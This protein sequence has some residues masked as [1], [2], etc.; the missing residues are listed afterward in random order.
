MTIVYGNQIE[1]GGMELDNSKCS[2]ECP[3]CKSQEAVSRHWEECEG[4]SINAYS[5]VSCPD[6]G[7][8]EG[9]DPND[10]HT[11]FDCD[12]A[13][14][15]EIMAD[16]DAEEKAINRLFPRAMRWVRNIGYGIRYGIKSRVQNAKTYVGQLVAS[17]K[18]RLPEI[19][20]NADKKKWELKLK[21]SLIIINAKC[22]AFI[23]LN[24]DCQLRWLWSLHSWRMGYLNAIYALKLLILSPILVPLWI[25]V[26][27]GRLTL[28]ESTRRNIMAWALKRPWIHQKLR[29]EGVKHR[30]VMRSLEEVRTSMAM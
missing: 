17:A 25:S 19:K 27:V 20:A 16:L 24:C 26:Q 4:G 29:D 10:D 18:A 12:N 28:Q 7:Y 13:W 23:Y 14:E 8:F 30:R 2:C 21:L 5:S 22:K 3:D 11:F 6:C 9:D 15:A 1:P